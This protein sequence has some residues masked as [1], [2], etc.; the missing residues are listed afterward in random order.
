MNVSWDQWPE[1]IAESVEPLLSEQDA[2]FYARIVREGGYN[3]NRL[4]W[5]VCL[6]G[7]CDELAAQLTRYLG[8][9]LLKSAGGGFHGRM[10]PLPTGYLLDDFDMVP[11]AASVN[12]L[13]LSE[14]FR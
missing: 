10:D 14:C 13:S 1:C 8:A 7:K 6:R 12:T 5:E 11:V 4:S 9:R 3:A 2:V